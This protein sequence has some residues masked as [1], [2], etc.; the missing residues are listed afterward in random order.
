MKKNMIRIGLTGLTL[1]LSIKAF[2]IIPVTDAGAQS[3]ITA[4]TT[5]DIIAG[6]DRAQEAVRAFNQGIKLY[7][8]AMN[9]F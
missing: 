4:Q 1:L 6:I 3:L 9:R 7:Q 2:A 5:N 8:N